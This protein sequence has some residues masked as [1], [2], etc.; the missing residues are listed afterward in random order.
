MTSAQTRTLE[1]LANGKVGLSSKTMAMW[2][3]FDILTREANYPHDPDDLDRCLLL[4]DR[5]P[6][7]RA[8]LS[9]MALL[10]EVWKA[11]VDRWD[12]IERTHLEEVGL[13]WTK[14]RSAP[15]TYELMRNVIRPVEDRLCS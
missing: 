3:A 15:R 10:G 2:L 12:E 1:W 4:L 11:L 14:A 5:V 13:G 9:R 6:E 7:M 8:Q